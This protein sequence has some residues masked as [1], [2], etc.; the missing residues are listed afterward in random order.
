MGLAVVTGASRGLGFESAKALASAG[1]DL[2]MI[3]KDPTRLSL[4]QQKVI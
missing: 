1:F 4:A 2:A 3:A